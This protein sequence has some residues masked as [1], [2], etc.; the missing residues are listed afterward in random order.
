MVGGSVGLGM[1]VLVGGGPCV[2]VGA[3]V[4]REIGTEIGRDWQED[5]RNTKPSQAAFFV[6]FIQ[7][8]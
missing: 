2:W 4:G 1:G 8:L 3:A 7:T 6:R 5:I